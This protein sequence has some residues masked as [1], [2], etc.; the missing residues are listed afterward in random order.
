MIPVIIP[1]YKAPD[2]LKICIEA[3][4]AQSYKPIEV[5]VRENS[6]DNVLYT[7]AINEGLRKFVSISE[8]ML[9]LTQDAYMEANCLEGLV[10]FMNENPKCGIAAPIQKSGDHVTWA[11][12]LTAFPAGPHDLKPCYKPK[13]TYWANGA[14]MLLRSEMVKEI[15]FMDKNMK[16]ICSDSD[17]S[18]TAR[19]RGWG[20]FVVP[21]AIVQHE[22]DGSAKTDNPW[23]TK[24]KIEDVE[25]FGKKW[26]TGAVYKDLSLEGNRLS[27][28]AVNSEM[29]RLKNYRE[30]LVSL[31][32]GL[33]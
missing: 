2:K 26:I 8:F 20:V 22:L 25:Y 4:K 9:V 19:S 30:K 5:F 3:V 11:G 28:A 31:H 27:R 18:F 21:E 12:S 33:A 6:E 15:G 32:A 23:L 14:C 16:F 24:I 1:H 29:Y 7:R 17:Y 10:R 13:E